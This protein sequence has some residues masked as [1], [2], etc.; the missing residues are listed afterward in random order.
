MKSGI[1]RL[2]AVLIIGI[3]AIA[4]GRAVLNSPDTKMSYS[5]LMGKIAAGEVTEVEISSDKTLAKVTLK[6]AETASR[7]AQKQVSIPSLDVFMDQI[8]ENIIS[9]Q[10]NV[11]QEEESA[12]LYIISAFSPIIIFIIFIIFCLVFMNPNQQGNKSMNFGKSKARML[13]QDTKS[14]VTFKDVAGIEEE[15]EELQE[16]V[17]FL[18]AP[19]KFTEMGARTMYYIYR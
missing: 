10:I 5:E 4:F 17:E 15:K 11:T 13:N 18:K 2:A 3:I 8:S 12:L 19:K 6:S 16:I 9:G 14:K 7:K 1:K